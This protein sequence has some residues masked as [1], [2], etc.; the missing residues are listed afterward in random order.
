MSL[1]LHNLKP[2]T[3]K[4]KKKRIGRGGKRGAYSGRGLKGQK[5]R[6]GGKRRLKRRGIRQL[7]E[8]THKLR[9]FKSHKPKVEILNLEKLNKYF[10]AQNV[11]K[12][13]YGHN[14]SGKKDLIKISPKILLKNKLISK[15][16]NGVKIL[17]KGDITVKL[18]V[19]NCAVS[20]S[21]KDKIEKAGGKVII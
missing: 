12:S 20:K 16:D 18:N 13:K 19:K 21:A 8:S 6:S 4:T 17:G 11:L 5:A 2:S 15:I 1:Y 7:I 3:I 14:I 10:S 9:G